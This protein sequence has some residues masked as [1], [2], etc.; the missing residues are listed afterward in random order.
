[1]KVST[2]ESDSTRP[3][4]APTYLSL[5][6]FQRTRPP[7]LC[8]LPPLASLGR[9]YTAQDKP[10][11]L[12]ISKD[13]RRIDYRLARVSSARA[14]IKIIRNTK[15]FDFDVFFIFFFYVFEFRI[16]PIRVGIMFLNLE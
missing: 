15:R 5:R 11:A 8:P 16:V 1:M 9:R 7:P 3:P 14:P 4:R 2:C 13:Y 12:Y 6:T 10:A